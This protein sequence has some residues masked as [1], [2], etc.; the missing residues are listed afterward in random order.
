MGC[1]ATAASTHM[2]GPKLSNRLNHQS[3]IVPVPFAVNTVHLRGTAWMLI[4]MLAGIR[5]HFGGINQRRFLHRSVMN[6]PRLAPA[7][8]KKVLET[9]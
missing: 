1:T 2:A 7:T 3:T 8:P 6:Q 9:R 5:A 4:A